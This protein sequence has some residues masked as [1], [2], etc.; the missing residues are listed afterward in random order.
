[1]GGDDAEGMFADQFFEDDLGKG[2]SQIGVAAAAQLIDKETGSSTG[3]LHEVLHVLQMR[4]IGA[5]LEFEALRIA[6]MDHQ[7][8]EDA[9]F[10]I[11]MDRHQQSALQHQLQQ[12]NRLQRHRFSAGIGAG[13]DE[14]AGLIVER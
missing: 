12:P 11:G 9:H 1:M 8:L 2:A 14:D 7:L 10:A 6:D 4:T 5:Q 3:I 13:D